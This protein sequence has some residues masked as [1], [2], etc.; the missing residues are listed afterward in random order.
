MD[1]DKA[2]PRIF[3]TG[4]AG[5]LGRAIA[6]KF[7]GCGWRVCI[8]DINDELGEKTRCEIE[9][10]Y[11]QAKPRSSCDNIALYYGCDVCSQQDIAL[12]RDRLIDA[13]GSVDVV[14]NNAGVAGNNALAEQVSLCDWEWTIDVN[15][16]G[17]VRVY[18]SFAT[19]FKQQKS[20]HFVNIASAAG[21]MNAPSMVNYNV[22]KAGLISFSESTRFELAK[23]GVH[24]SL[25]CPGF[26]ATN[27]AHSIRGADGKLSEYSR[28]KIEK[29]MLR[30]N[31]SAEDVAHDIFMAVKKK[32]FWVH[33][34]SAMKYLWR[35]KRLMPEL[36]FTLLMKKYTRYTRGV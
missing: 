30:S 18:R 11:R 25:V 28:K 22:T 33:P 36:F 2:G 4:G 23:F 7:A 29:R 17:A 8:G 3:I 12:L 5:G 15:I 1:N 14:V 27:I 35:L 20:G 6:L 34:H 13:W 19:V 32:V 31:I 16:L 9:A 26:F 10:A 21:L 24:V